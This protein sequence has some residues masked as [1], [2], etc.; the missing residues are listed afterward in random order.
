MNWN[1]TGLRFREADLRKPYQVN[2]KITAQVIETDI[3]PFLSQ[4]ADPKFT[5][6]NWKDIID[7]VNHVKG[8]LAGPLD[9]RCLGVGADYRRWDADSGG[10]FRPVIRGSWPIVA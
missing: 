8:D 7:Q 2:D 3:T 5:R 10:G 6:D 9:E 1:T 4:I